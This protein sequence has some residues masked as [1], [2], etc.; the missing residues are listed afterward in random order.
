MTTQEPSYCLRLI[1]G[2]LEVEKS[3]SVQFPRVERRNIT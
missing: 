2:M 3:F 1:W